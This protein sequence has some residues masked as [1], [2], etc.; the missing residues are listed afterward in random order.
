MAAG[1]LDC[2]DCIVEHL[3]LRFFELVLEMNVAGG[4][5]R[6]DARAAGML[7]RSGS[8]LDIERTAPRQRRDLCPR[9][10]TADSVH[11][12]KIAIGG[13]RETSLEYID[14]QVHQL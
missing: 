14:T 9:G 6:M 13:N 4:D 12:L 11:R 5:K 2:G 8:A 10:L 1:Q 7:E 3:L